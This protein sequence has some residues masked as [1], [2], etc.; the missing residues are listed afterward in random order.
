MDVT[1]D[2]VYCRLHGSAE[3]YASGYAGT[4]LDDWA[5][6]VMAWATGKEPA[7]AERI[8]GHARSRARDVFVYFDNTMKIRAPADARSLEARIR[9]LLAEQFSPVQ[10]P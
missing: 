1:A 7:D 9:D 3:L 5:R 2:F 10:A 8:D 6:R 4:A